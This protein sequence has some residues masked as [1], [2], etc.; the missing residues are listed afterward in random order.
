MVDSTTQCP[1]IQNI[2]WSRSAP[3]LPGKIGA[4]RDQLVFCIIG[5]Y[6]EYDATT[7]WPYALKMSFICNRYAGV[8]AQICNDA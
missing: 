7:L 4:E 2:S 3:I 5:H 6:L 1:L 8:L